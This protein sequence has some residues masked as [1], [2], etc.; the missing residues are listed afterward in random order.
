MVPEH[1]KE[2]PG[3]CMPTVYA[4]WHACT[5]FL[6][7]CPCCCVYAQDCIIEGEAFS[8]NADRGSIVQMWTFK[9]F[10]SGPE[11]CVVLCVPHLHTRTHRRTRKRTR[12]QRAPPYSMH[13]CRPSTS[14]CACLLPAMLPQVVVKAC[15]ITKWWQFEIFSNEIQTHF[16]T[17]GDDVF[18][19]LLAA[20][21]DLEKGM[22]IMVMPKMDQ[23][24]LDL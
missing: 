11:V 1:A 10:H 16:K 13:V 6:L 20:E 22:G 7:L 17:H 15:D 12:S 2:Y 8:M 14:V 19:P 5:A 24:L 23:S 18:M 4:L 3:L 9:G 21:L